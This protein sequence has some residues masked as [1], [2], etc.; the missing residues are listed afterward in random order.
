MTF[1]SSLWIFQASLPSTLSS[2]TVALSES[3][4]LFGSEE[5]FLMLSM[6]SLNPVLDEPSA[7]ISSHLSAILSVLDAA[8]EPELVCVKKA[9]LAF[10]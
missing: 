3:S 2:D 1:L 4:F 8:G 6:S 7:G 10:M 5:S 9:L